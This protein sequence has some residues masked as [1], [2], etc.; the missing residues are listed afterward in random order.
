MQYSWNESGERVSR[1][2]HRFLGYATDLSRSGARA[3]LDALIAAEEIAWQ[4]RPGPSTGG[5]RAI[6]DKCKIGA[7]SELSVSS[8]LLL[9]GFEVLAMR[10]PV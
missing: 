5:K 6:T 7:A 3:K 1:E 9:R 10:N 4:T 2:Q 8:D